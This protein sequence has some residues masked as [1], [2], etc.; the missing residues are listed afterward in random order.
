MRIR[1]TEDYKKYLAMLGKCTCA[2]CQGKKHCGQVANNC[3]FPKGA[4][5]KEEEE[6]PL[7]EVAS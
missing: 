4:A 1:T 7:S 3:G 2:C 6:A 5:A